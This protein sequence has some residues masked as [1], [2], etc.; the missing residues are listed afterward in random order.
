MSK[1]SKFLSFVLRHNPDEI[2]I[3]LRDSFLM[4]PL[5]SISG[6]VVAGPAE[7]HVFDDDYP[8]CEDCDTRGCRRRIRAILKH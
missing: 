3:T 1:L 5:K 8:F 2:G 4:E 7:I 6:V